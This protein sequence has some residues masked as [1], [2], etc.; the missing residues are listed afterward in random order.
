MLG[1]FL[2]V[3]HQ[4]LGIGGVF[5]GRRA[6]LSGAGNR[7]DGD[8]VVTKPD[9]DFRARP[10]NR[11]I[12]EIEEEQEWRR[13]QPSQAAIQIDRRQMEWDREPLRQDHLENIACADVTFCPVDHV[14]EVV[15]RHV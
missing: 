7:P 10:D 11:Q 6:A 15:L 3:A 2:D 1:T 8:D 5:L 4:V 12:V 9:K 14:E 13:V